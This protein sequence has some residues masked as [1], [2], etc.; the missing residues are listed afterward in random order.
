MSRDVSRRLPAY[1]ACHDARLILGL[2]EARTIVRGY[3]RWGQSQRPK[4]RPH[5]TR[6]QSVIYLVIRPGLILE[7]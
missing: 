4:L 7:T 6:L 2:S 1:V 5:N 3:I